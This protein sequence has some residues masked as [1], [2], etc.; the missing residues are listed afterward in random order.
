MKKNSASAYWLVILARELT[1]LLKACLNPHKYNIPSK[2]NIST[3]TLSITQQYNRSK[4]V[5][6][7]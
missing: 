7:M 5:N 1:D 2:N 4:A 6:K 3:E